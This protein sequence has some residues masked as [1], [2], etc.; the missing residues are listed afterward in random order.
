MDLLKELMLLIDPEIVLCGGT[1][2]LFEKLSEPLKPIGDTGFVYSTGKTV[3]IDYWHPAVF[4]YPDK[5]CY[6]AL[7]TLIQKAGISNQRSTHLA[8]HHVCY[9]GKIGF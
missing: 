6:Y 9:V 3:V 8:A 1:F 2:G 4:S 7:C 5:M